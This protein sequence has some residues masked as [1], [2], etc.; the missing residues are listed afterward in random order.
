MKIKFRSKR[1]SRSLGGDI[2]LFT[3]LLIF[4]AFTALPLV[5]VITNAFKPLNEL[6]IFPPRFFVRNPTLDNF[7]TLSVVMSNSWIPFSRYI[8]NTLF[9]SIIGTAGHVIFASMAAYV[10]SKH[11]FPGRK[12]F[13]ATVVLSLM[14][15][16]E[17]LSI[18]NYL[19]MSKIGW[20]D[21]LTALIIPAWAMSLG[22]FLMKQFMETMVPDSLLEAAKIDG[23]SEWRIFWQI[24]MP[25]VKP[26]WLTLMILAFQRLWQMVPGQYIYSEEMKTLSYAINQIMQGGRAREG[27]M[28]AVSLLMMIVP[29]VIF[30]VNQ[31]KVVETMGTSG[32][33]D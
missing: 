7:K 6:F 1:V 9:L 26:A 8:F 25:I 31:S 5:L 12:V 18:P 21:S 19:I 10:L 32:I 14:F 30:V 17:V 15:A 20:V 27:V 29:I 33:K 3:I 4:A 23:A 2:A 22:L 24:V 16:P 11:R 28:A 13:F